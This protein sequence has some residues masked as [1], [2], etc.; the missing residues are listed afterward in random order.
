MHLNSAIQICLSEFF[1]IQVLQSPINITTSNRS[2]SKTDLPPTTLSIKFDLV[3]F[4]E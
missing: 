4:R 2:I 3:P 1:H